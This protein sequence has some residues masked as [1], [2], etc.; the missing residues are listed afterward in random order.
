MDAERAAILAKERAKYRDRLAVALT[1]DADPLA[2]YNEFV[3]WTV[4]AYKNHLGQSGL[5]QLLDEATRYFVDDDAYRSDLR[6]LKL[7]LLYARHV[8]DPITI[9]A[10]LLSRNIGRIYA[11]TY[12]EY[13]EALYKRGK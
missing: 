13:A 1:E 7:W 12:Q 11:Q 10:F 9:H 8:E 5:I 6:Y 2:A 4:D 3:K